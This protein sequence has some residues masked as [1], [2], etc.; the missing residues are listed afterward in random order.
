[1]VSCLVFKS[2]SHFEF[3]FIHGVRLCSSF[4]D[5]HVGQVFPTP[6]AEKPV[7][8]PFYILASFFEE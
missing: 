1:M 5:L 2:L 4:I 3:I 8:S 6:F 7:F